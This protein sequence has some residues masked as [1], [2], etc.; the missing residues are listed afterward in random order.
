MTKIEKVEQPGIPRA[1][2]VMLAGGVLLF[3][4]PLL[5]ICALL[6]KLSSPGPALFRQK[7][8]GAG[9]REFT[10]YKLRTMRAEAKGSLVTAANDSRI[11]GIGKI[12]R[13]TKLDELP[14]LWNVVEGTMSLVGPRP[15]VPALVDLSDPLWQQV[16][17]VN[18]GLTDPVT[19]KLRNEETLMAGVDG[20]KDLFYRE[21]LQPYKL[22]GY[23]DYIKKRT[24]QTDAA[25]LFQTIYAVINPRST[26]PP[27]L[28]ELI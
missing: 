2:E 5:L 16:L 12:L 22:K 20:S 7:R 27:K 6:I 19:L 26:P 17:E 1:I 9:G 14:E 3:F 23:I 15:E 21:V 18:P 10:L 28:E 4:L 8:M 25:I 24:W 11:T 13:K